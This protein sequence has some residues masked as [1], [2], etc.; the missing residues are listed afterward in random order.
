MSGREIDD[1]LLFRDD[2]S[3]F[4]VHLT[5]NTENSA[6]TN[7]ENIL[8]SKELVYENN[9]ISDARFGHPFK[10]IN[11][12]G[13]EYFSAV[14]FTETPINEIHNLL[15]ISGRAVDLQP[16]GLVFL[17]NNLQ[18]KGVSPVFYLNNML[19]DK[20]DLVLALCS[21][22]NSNPLEAKQILPYISVFGQHLKP[23]GAT[24]T[25]GTI[26]FMWE[27]EWRYASISNKFQFDLTDVFIG[28]CPDDEINHFET[29]FPDLMFIDP[30]RNR[31][32]YAGKL[33]AARK[34]SDLKNSV[35]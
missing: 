17:K 13:L 26:N 4:L 33:I 22:I 2:I 16:Y 27:R 5:K 20:N 34:R 8:N 9:K 29:L 7:L 35:V 14:C 3:P 25:P 23:N 18:E 15:E 19:D 31:K 32:W 1:V 30:R 11:E 12:F 24:H 21:L 28:L 10:S 6:K